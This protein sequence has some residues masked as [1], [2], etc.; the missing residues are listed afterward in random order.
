MPELYSG[1]IIFFCRLVKTGGYSSEKIFYSDEVCDFD[2]CHYLNVKYG[3]KIH[4]IYP[5]LHLGLHGGR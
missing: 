5:W 3:L 4:L 1:K 2:H